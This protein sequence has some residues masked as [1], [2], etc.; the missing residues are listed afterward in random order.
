MFGSTGID[1]CS[2][3]AGT[4]TCDGGTPGTPVPTPD[5]PDICDD[6]VET[7]VNCRGD[8]AH[9]WDGIASGKLL[10]N[11]ITESWSATY[12]M[13]LSLDGGRHQDLQRQRGIDW[14]IGGT[15]PS[16]CTTAARPR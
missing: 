5:D 12:G 8:S 10:Y 1:R 7:K 14:S 9:A 6:T 4:D 15:T 16:G 2:G 11:G 13:N 3:G